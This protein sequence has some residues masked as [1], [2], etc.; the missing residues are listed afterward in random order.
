MAT[1]NPDFTASA[2]V[3]ATLPV[4]NNGSSVQDLDLADGTSSPF[5]PTVAGTIVYGFTVEISCLTITTAA[6]LVVLDTGSNKSLWGVL[7][8]APRQSCSPVSLGPGGYAI[9]GQ[10]SLEWVGLGTGYVAVACTW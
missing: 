8:N 5:G 3:Q 9:T 2:K 10:L 1:D 7:L 6:L 4:T